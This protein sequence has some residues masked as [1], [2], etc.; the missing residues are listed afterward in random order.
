MWLNRKD[1]VSGLSERF[2]VHVQAAVDLPDRGTGG[3]TVYNQG[4]VCG[5]LREKHTRKR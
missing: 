5:A 4:F 2:Q 1:G 3:F